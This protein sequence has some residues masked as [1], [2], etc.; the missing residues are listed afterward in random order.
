M[1]DSVSPC[2][3]MNLQFIKNYLAME[4]SLGENLQMTGILKIY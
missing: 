3:W 1:G 2:Y 4:E